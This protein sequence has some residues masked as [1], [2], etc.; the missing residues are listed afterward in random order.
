MRGMRRVSVRRCALGKGVFACRRFRRHQIIGQV[1]GSLRRERQSAGEHLIDAGSGLC[2]DPYPPFRFLNH[3]CRPNAELVVS[4]A[5]AGGLPETFVVALRELRV[6]E[7]L[8]IDYAWE[9]DLVERCFCGEDACRGWIVSRLEA[10]R[11]RT[12]RDPRRRTRPLST[13]RRRPT[14][15]S[16]R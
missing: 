4:Q 3:S 16:R 7:E 12:I 15:R 2:L 5:R 11:L 8:L 1:E 6:G 10:A 9:A 13:R 14:E